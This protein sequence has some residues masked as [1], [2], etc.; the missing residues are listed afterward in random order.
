MLKAISLKWLCIHLKTAH[1]HT[2]VTDTKTLGILL[3]PLPLPLLL[4]VAHIFY[5]TFIHT[6]TYCGCCHT[7]H[8]HRIWMNFVCWIKL[9]GKKM[10]KQR[11][12]HKKA[13]FYSFLLFVWFIFWKGLCAHIALDRA[14]IALIYI[15]VDGFILTF[16]YIVAG[17]NWCMAESH[18]K[19]T[20]KTNISNRINLSNACM[21]LLPSISISIYWWLNARAHLMET[22]ELDRQVQFLSVQFTGCCCRYCNEFFMRFRTSFW[23]KHKW[24]W[25]VWLSSRNPFF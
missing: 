11:R 24:W 18:K 2:H 14:H 25:N 20:M 8:I 19:T 10:S 5:H 17:P 23:R 22:N 4:V 6:H 21:Y 13:E 1:E 12:Q 15:I 3:L 16:Y 9:F 7:R